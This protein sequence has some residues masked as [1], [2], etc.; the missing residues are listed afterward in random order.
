MFHDFDHDVLHYYMDPLT[1]LYSCKFSLHLNPCIQLKLIKSSPPLNY[2][3][4]DYLPGYLTFQYFGTQLGND[5]LV[6]AS[7]NHDFGKMEDHN[8]G[9]IEV[10]IKCI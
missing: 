7:F 10:C 9:K 6:E 5:K 2:I 3:T 1:R 8:F 4:I